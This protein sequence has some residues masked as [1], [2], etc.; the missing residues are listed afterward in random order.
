MGYVLKSLQAMDIAKLPVDK[1]ASGDVEKV[2]N[3]YGRRA[4]VQAYRYLELISGAMGEAK[5]QGCRSDNPADRDNLDLKIKHTSERHYGWHFDELPRLWSLLCEA[6]TD[7]NRDGLWTTAQIA[8]GAGVDRAAVLNRIK[9]KNADG[10]PMLP[11]KQLNVGK[12]ATYL[13]DPADAEKAGLRIVNTNAESNFNEMH[14]AIQVLKFALL[15]GVR[16]NEANEMQW[17]EIDDR[18]NVWTIPKERTKS[19][20]KHVVPLI[21]PALAIVEKRRPH[22]HPTK[23]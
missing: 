5:K 12:T 18:R 17:N 7:C 4:P 13:I 9:H 19:K 11:A 1:V 22:R 23:P 15:T 2:I 20:R 16:F 14:L 3:D 10:T 21:D 6:E 8:K